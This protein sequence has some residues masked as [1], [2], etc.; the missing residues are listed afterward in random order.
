MEILI[1]S[2]RIVDTGSPFNNQVKD[3]LI[4]NGKI[5]KIGSRL[6]NTTKAKEI[7]EDNLHVSIGWLDLNTFLADPGFEQKETI[8]TGCR[9]AAAGGFTHICCMPNTQPVIQT[10][11]QV[12]YVL[13]KSANQLVTVHPLGAV[14]HNTDGHDLADMY[15]LHHAGAIAFS[16][17]PK[18]LPTAGVVERALLYVKAFDGLIMVHPEDKSVSKNGAMHEGLV[19]TQLG[20]PGAPALAEEIAVNRDLFVLEYTGSKLH[21]LDISLKRS[22]DLIRAAKKKKLNITASVNAYNLLLDQTA[23]A[24]YNT[25]CKVN[26]HL[27]AKEDIAALVKGINDGTI[28]A[29]SSAHHPHEEDCKKLE[30]DKADFGMIGLETCYGVVNT[31]L[32][33]S[34]TT[35]TI[36]Q[37]LAQNP[38][39]ILGLELISIK[40][41]EAAD[42]TLFNPEKKKIFTEKDIR[43]R[44]KNTPFIGTEFT[45]T[46]TG[47]INK[48]KLHL[49]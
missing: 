40:E 4:S 43:S 45:G 10:K 35:E 19:S 15:D 49:N 34:V 41:G 16:D 31:A 44:S 8:E 24:D 30:F 39:K 38:R 22:V 32:K 28:D 12:E 9:A 17:G 3:I 21:L 26:P 46:V 20:L 1:R 11:A 18:P 14:T 42:L 23:V 37:L 25:Q 5:K 2:A 13:G 6:Q 7:N 36:V 27:R 29:I 48:G 47:V 33:G